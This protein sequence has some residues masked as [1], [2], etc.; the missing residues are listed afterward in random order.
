MN[1]TGA[2][3]AGGISEEEEQARMAVM[4]NKLQTGDAYAPPPLS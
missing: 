2:A 3:A 1:T 4:V